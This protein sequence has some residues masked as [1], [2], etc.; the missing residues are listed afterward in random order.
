MQPFQVAFFSV[1][2]V[3]FFERF[4]FVPKPEF[5]TL[6]FRF[7]ENLDLRIILRRLVIGSNK[8]F[9]NYDGNSPEWVIS[10]YEK[11]ELIVDRFVDLTGIIFD[12]ESCVITK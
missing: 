9:H 11:K 4:V 12:A 8:G 1:V 5:R 10:N 7:S 2:R 6:R 3:F